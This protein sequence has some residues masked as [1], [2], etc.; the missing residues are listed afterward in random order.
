MR[1]PVYPC[2]SD[3]RR[4]VSMSNKKALRRRGL[5]LVHTSFFQLKQVDFGN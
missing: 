3:W 5:S 1:Y 4:A 2:S